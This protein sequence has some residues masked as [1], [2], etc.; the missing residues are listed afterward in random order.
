MQELKDAA[1]FTVPLP[2]LV[3]ISL[4]NLPPTS[5]FRE[6]QNFLIHP[7]SYLA[8]PFQEISDSLGSPEILIK[9]SL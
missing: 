7:L 9:L 1:R 6:I 4:C 3:P 5:A 8:E 2:P